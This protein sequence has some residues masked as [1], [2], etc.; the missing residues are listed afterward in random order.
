M[1]WRWLVIKMTNMHTMFITDTTPAA[2]LAVTAA[3][4]MSM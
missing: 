1:L 2:L 3:F 4:G